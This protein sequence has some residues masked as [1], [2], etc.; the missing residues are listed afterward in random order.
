MTFPRLGSF[1][2]LLVLAV[3]MGLPGAAGGCQSDAKSQPQPQS[4][5]P[6]RAQKSDWSSKQSLGQLPR[7]SLG[8]MF[9][10]DPAIPTVASAAASPALNEAALSLLLKASES[11][12]A[13]LRAQ[14]LEALQPLPSVVEPAARKALVD[15]NRGVRFTAT[16]IIG[17][18]KL[19]DSAY[20]LE[21]LLRDSSKSVQAAAIYSLR[22]CERPVDLNPL[23]VLIMDEDP[24]V[25]GNAAMVLGLLADPSA[26]PM[27]QAAL[28]RPMA[29][30]PPQRAK[31]VDLQMAAALVRL[32]DYEYLDPIRA[33]FFTPPEQYELTALACLLAGEIQDTGAVGDL[34]NIAMR[35]DQFAQP[36]EVRMAATQALTEIDRAR[37]DL[38]IPLRYAVDEQYQIRAQAAAV[39]GRIG[40]PAALPTLQQ[41]LYD[42]NPLV[43]VSAAGGI[44][45]IA[46][47]SSTLATALPSPELSNPVGK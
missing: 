13:L 26:L 21:P 17:R 4:A 35:E 39:M 22:R 10:V 41:L 15:D 42:P 2:S 43:Q 19:T 32:G 37:A 20:L 30:V 31:I 28:Q 9:P 7:P 8:P 38:N 40:N 47:P 11:S 23:A 36:A 6:P 33:A 5:P 46:A 1:A 34:Y 14:A 18:L 45:R 29:H 24:E 3:A 16:M 12:N 44:L 27:V 25:R